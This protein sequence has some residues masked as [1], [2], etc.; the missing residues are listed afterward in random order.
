LESPIIPEIR[1]IHE[2]LRRGGSKKTEH[3]V[4]IDS[5]REHASKARAY[6]AEPRIPRKAA[7]RVFPSVGSTMLTEEAGHATTGGGGRKTRGNRQ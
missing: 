4:R 5:P 2:N 3:Q 1:K 6:I 7:P